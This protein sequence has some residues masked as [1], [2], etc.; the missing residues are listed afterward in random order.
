MKKLFFVKM[1]W[2]W[3]DFILKNEEDLSKININLSKELIEKMCSRHFWIWADWVLLVSLKNKKNAY[4]MYN[5]DWSRAELCWNSLRCFMKYIIS[6]KKY[7]ENISSIRIKTDTW[8]MKI[9]MNSW[10]IVA[11]MWKPSKIK[12]LVYTNKNLWDRF[13]LKIYDEEFIFTP[14]S[15]WN[16]HA[17]IFLKENNI[18][19][20]NFET[21]DISI[22]WKKIE[23]HTD[24]F[25]NKTNVEFVKIISKKELI[26]RIWERWVWETLSCWT[27]ACAVVVAGI[28][29][30]KLDKDCFIK[31]NI[32]WWILEVKW[33]W[34]SNDS[35]I[36]KW[37]ANEVFEWYY[38]IDSNEQKK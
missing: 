34:N 35:I 12:N 2:T 23:N 8:I 11:N 15:I 19:Y 9:S 28:L 29:A 21:I 7:S 14:I 26:M 6:R 38:F 32:L 18:L 27:C 33:S 24:I 37:N 16:P 10:F 13:P 1:E 36:L 4:Q 17:V 31:V 20:N 3:N 30:N 5:P 22:Y 25:P